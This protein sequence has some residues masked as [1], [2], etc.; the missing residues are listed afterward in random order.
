MKYLFGILI[1]TFCF[2]V[3]SIALGADPDVSG[4]TVT[5]TPAYTPMVGI[6]GL[7]KVSTY[8][9]EMYVDALYKLAITVG[10]IL[11]V[12]QI[13]FGGV[14]YM[15]DGSITN[16][17]AGKDKIKGA[18]F[19]LL[20]ILGAVLLLQTINPDLLN[21]KIFNNAPSIDQISAAKNEV[22]QKPAQP[23]DS[24]SATD[25]AAVKLLKDTCAGPTGSLAGGAA[26][27]GG[28]QIT[29]YA[30]AKNVTATIGSTFDEILYLPTE[31]SI[32]LTS[33]NQSCTS[34]GG[35]TNT[36]AFGTNQ[37]NQRPLTNEEIGETQSGNAL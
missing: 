35:V 25:P 5:K 3:A 33:Y 24:V 20:I 34:G 9:A 11:A 14:M 15:F 31:R 7:A 23:R 28:S 37:C 6:P 8:T 19:G 30:S 16:K 26:R 17:E 10:G 13:I 29:C 22:T 2:G 1:F 18:L 4:K 12:I 27:G 32:A 21:L 36:T